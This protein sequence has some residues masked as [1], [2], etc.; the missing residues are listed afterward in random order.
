M[1]LREIVFFAEYAQNMNNHTFFLNKFAESADI[2][3]T[4]KKFG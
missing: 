2:H 3:Y 4:G 1:V